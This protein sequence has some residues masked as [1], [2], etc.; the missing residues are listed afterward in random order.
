MTDAPKSGEEIR[1]G[2]TMIRY[3]PPDICYLEVVG[4]PDVAEAIKLMDAVRRFSEGKDVFFTLN[5]VAR[6]S[7]FPPDARRFV[8]DRM[9][10]MPIRGIAIF[11]ASFHM[12]VVLTL[13]S[14][15]RGLVFGD[16]KRSPMHIFATEA[17]ARAWIAEQ[18][19][20]AARGA[21]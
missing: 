4:A 5:N 3:E 7:G 20:A 6:T 8:A 12:R 16:Q 17:E 19:A 21:L 15:A 9:R 18:R 10:A 13:F 1:I 14:K 11:G 2:E